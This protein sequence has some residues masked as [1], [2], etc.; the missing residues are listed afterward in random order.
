MNHFQK[1]DYF[2]SFLVQLIA[3]SDALFA[4][5]SPSRIGVSDLIFGVGTDEPLQ[6]C[7]EAVLKQRD[8]CQL[9]GKRKRPAAT[10]IGE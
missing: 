10:I 2:E 3:D 1:I 7:L 4:V 5:F 6:A 8:V 9:V